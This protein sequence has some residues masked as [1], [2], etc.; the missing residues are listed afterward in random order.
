MKHSKAKKTKTV[1]P[2]QATDTGHTDDDSG[3]AAP[4]AQH[5]FPLRRQHRVL[6]GC[7]MLIQWDLPGSPTPYSHRIEPCEAWMNA[8]VLMQL[9]DLFASWRKRLPQRTWKP[10]CFAGWLLHACLHPCSSPS[11]V[12]RQARMCEM[13]CAKML[14]HGSFMPHE[15]HNTGT[16]SSLHAGRFLLIID[17]A[18]A[19]LRTVRSFKADLALESRPQPQSEQLADSRSITQ[20][21]HRLLRKRNSLEKDCF[22]A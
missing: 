9:Q 5:L 22:F 1:K 3:H 10:I 7:S 19:Q 16:Y 8:D 14:H 18:S 21:N 20:S 17:D 13:A 4:N 12:A 6:P 15:L 11:T 2:K